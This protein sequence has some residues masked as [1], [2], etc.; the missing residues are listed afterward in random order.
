MPHSLEPRSL[1]L[2]I[3]VP[4]IKPVSGGGLELCN[5]FLK[6][7]KRKSYLGQ[8]LLSITSL[9][10]HW[11]QVSNLGI[12]EGRTSPN[13]LHY[14]FGFWSFIAQTIVPLP[15]RVPRKWLLM[16]AKPKITWHL[17]SDI[18]STHWLPNTFCIKTLCLQLLIFLKPLGL[19]LS[20]SDI[21]FVCIDWLIGGVKPVNAVNV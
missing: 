18:G 20:M 8:L 1:H 4:F 13:L 9:P 3:L 19:K 16:Q 14:Q 6:S 10:P 5:G 21:C 11:L 2:L 15:F 17:S 12:N 7:L